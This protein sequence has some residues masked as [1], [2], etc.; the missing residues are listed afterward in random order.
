MFH[1]FALCCS[2]H[3][4]S[5]ECSCAGGWTGL[6][7]NETCPPGYY[8]EACMLPCSC[9]NGADCHPV[10]GACVCAPGFMVSASIMSV[11][12]EFIFYWFVF[13][14]WFDLYFVTWVYE[15]NHTPAPTDGRQ[16]KK[17]KKHWK[18]QLLDAFKMSGFCILM[19]WAVS[20]WVTFLHS[21][22]WLHSSSNPTSLSL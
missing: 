1:L 14:F 20:F 15:N 9:S 6:Y 4:L 13:R 19:K 3:P 17:Q 11:A 2:C 8:G 16:G 12:I 7:C 22:C 10:T 5:G 18:N 21:C